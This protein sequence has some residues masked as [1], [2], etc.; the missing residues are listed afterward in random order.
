MKGR[1]YRDR[2]GVAALEFALIASIMVTMILGTIE[3][4]NIFRAQAKLNVAAGQLVEM[5]AGQASVT[6]GSANGPGGSLGDLCTAASYNMLPYSPS[7]LSAWIESTTVIQSGSG[8]GTKQDW[9]TDM[10]CPA[11]SQAGSFTETI[12][13]TNIA[14]TPRSLFTQDGTPRAS[15]G[16]LVKGYTAISLRLTYT[17]VNALPFLRGRT[18]TFTAVAAARPRANA[19]VTCTYPSGSG[20][21][22]CPGVY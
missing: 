18:L 19:A 22:S 17:Y 3:F 14:D 10:A 9:A 11:S 21:A 4:S 20:T 15:G 16:T 1:L 12:V 5:I 13:L 2:S 6:Q 8:L 7:R